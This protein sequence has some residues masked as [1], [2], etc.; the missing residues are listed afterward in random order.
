MW[1]ISSNFFGH[2][3]RPYALSFDSGYAAKVVNYA[4]KGFIK[5]ASGAYPIKHFFCKLD[6]FINANNIISVL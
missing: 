1:P 2:N 3:L 5:L 6:H 4:E